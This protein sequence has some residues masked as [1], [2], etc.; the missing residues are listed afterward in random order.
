MKHLNKRKR[1]VQ[2]N[3]TD[4]ES[5]KL[6]SAGGVIQGYNGLA[7]SDQKHQVIV[8]ADTAGQNDERPS[9]KPMVEKVRHNLS[10]DDPFKTGKFSGDSGFCDEPNLKFLSENKIDSYIPDL[11]FRQRDK[12]FEKAERYYP[13][14]RRKTGGKFKPKDFIVDPIAQT[15][16][17]PGGKQM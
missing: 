12:R 7:I 11:R 2:S 6:K 14:E 16:T 4:N 3:I 8:S 5:A 15:V 17:C 1:V 13:K 10:S 9:L